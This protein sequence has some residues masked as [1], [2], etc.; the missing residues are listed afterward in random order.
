M[1]NAKFY[2]LEDEYPRNIVF[3]LC[4][5]DWFLRRDYMKKSM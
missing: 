4:P 5:W 2:D 1:R 3:K